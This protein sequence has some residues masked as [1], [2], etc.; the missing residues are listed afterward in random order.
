MIKR[1]IKRERAAKN[2]KRSIIRSLR[3]QGFRIE[4]G[5]IGPLS[6]LDKT[7]VRQLHR[8]AVLHKLKEEAPYIRPHED[9][10]LQRVANGNDIDP[11]AIRPKLVQVAEGTFESLLF[12]YLQLHWSIPV[13]RGYGR[14]LRFLIIDENNANV[15]GLIGLGD[16]VYSLGVRDKWI[17][18]DA[19]TKKQRLYHVMDAYVLGAIPPYSHLLGSKLVALLALST[20]VR[21]AF[22]QKYESRQSLLRR[23]IR[24]ASE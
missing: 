12:R 10:F 4:R 21:Q 13:S 14:R 6:D 17:G 22:V 1:T 9:E 11:Y 24:P 8:T 18:W 19:E 5:L 2:L 7:A 16:P 20:E 3:R 15:I 23:E